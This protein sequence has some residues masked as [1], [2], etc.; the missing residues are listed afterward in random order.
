MRTP[1][2]RQVERGL[3]AGTSRGAEPPPQLA[4][5]RGADREPV[6]ARASSPGGTRMPV[7][8]STT[9]SA[10]P[11]TRDATTGS[12]AAIASS[13]DTGRPSD[14]LESTKTSDPARSSGTSLRSPASWTRS[15]SPSLWISASTSLRSG[16]SPTIRASYSWSASAASARISV[17]K[18]FGAFS[19]PTAIS[20]GVARSWRERGSG[21]HV[22]RV[23]DH[24]AALGTARACL[25]PRSELGLGDADRHGRQRGHQPVRDAVEAGSQ[26]GVRGE[27]PTVD[28]EE[29][30]RHA[31]RRRGE[32]AEDSR[33]RA[34]RV[35]DLGPLPSEE[36]D[37]LDQAGEIAHRIDRP[38]DV[39][40]RDETRSR[41][42]RLLA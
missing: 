36:S 2:R 34:A 25:E 39:L 23:V 21:G 9:S 12:S 35:Q 27:G 20:R 7:S 38:P 22:D 15:S 4:V 32:T 16:P 33:L 8:P 37:Q 10:S 42:G 18:S 40:Q 24:H 28:R 13:T 1:E 29:A 19:R 17:R 30:D 3:G 26:A 41:S 6:P 14:R 5:C 11:P 31:G